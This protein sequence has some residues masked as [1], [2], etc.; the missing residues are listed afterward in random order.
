MRI[1]LFTPILLTLVL[2]LESCKSGGSGSNSDDFAGGEKV[3]RIAEVI[4]PVSIFP[5]RIT[6]VVEGLIASQIHEGLVRINPVDLSIVPGLAEK[7]EIN[8][9]GKT[10]TFHLRKGLKFQN[11]DGVEG[12]ITSKD[13][14]FTFELLCTDR[15]GNVQFETVCKDRIVGANEY[16]QANIKGQ[17][18]QLKGLK[19]IDELTFSIELLNSPNIF[20][21][22]LANPVASIISEQGYKLK[23]EDTKVGAGPFVL[24]EK[25]STKTHFALYKN[26]NYYGKDKAG[27]SLPYIDSVIIDIVSS[28]EVALQRFQHGNIDFIGSVPSNQLR[29]V[30][31]ENIKSFKGNPA[32]FILD[33]RPEMGT[34]YYVFNVNHPPFNNIKLRQAINYGIDRAKIIDRVLNGQAYGPAING[35]VPPTFDF[36]KSYSIKGYDLDIEKAK[37]L[38]AE[39]GYPNGKGLAEIQLIVNSG[40]SRNNT[41]AGEIQKQLKNNLNINI[42]FESLP[43]PEKF[44]LQL[45]GKG[46]IFRDGWVADYPSPESFLSIFYGEPVTNDTTR[47]SYPNTIKYKNSEYDKY[48]KKGRDALNRDTAAIYFL[49]AEQI[50]MNDAPLIPLWYESNCRLIKT[51]LK[52]FHVNPIRYFD[53]TQVIIEDKK[54]EEKK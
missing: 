4:I 34:S 6:N 43:N 18:A 50:L 3:V 2:F 5:H 32:L 37:K 47:M 19:I 45:K 14:K 46:D 17:K 13:V 12:N 30:V 51:R 25:S 39:A 11:K 16:F 40:N 20:L 27:K 15:P 53:F 29:Q 36:Y 10:I 33:Q 49:K 41:V 31:E 35:I 28:T 1:S 7:W 52:N 23:K 38:L 44:A 42:T 24:D 54:V 9:D 21:E 8:P 22:I 26:V 48:Y